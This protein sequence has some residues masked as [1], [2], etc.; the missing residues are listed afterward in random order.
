MSAL[1]L[2]EMYWPMG[3]YRAWNRHCVSLCMEMVFKSNSVLFR[4]IG[5]HAF[6]AQ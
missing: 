3:A 5:F 4:V 6:M 2:L 1:Y